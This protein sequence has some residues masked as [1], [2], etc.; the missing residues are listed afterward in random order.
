MT[1]RSLPLAASTLA[2]F[3]LAI[4]HPA[5]AVPPAAAEACDSRGNSSVD[6]GVIAW[7]DE[8]ALNTAL[9]YANRQWSTNGLTQVKLKRDDASNIADLQW[10][11]VNRTDG[12]WATRDAQWA[13]HTGA[14][15]VYFNLARL[16]DGKV[17][18]TEYHRAHVAAHELGHALGLCHTTLHEYS[19]MWPR[20]SDL[21]SENINGPMPYDRTA[22]HKLWG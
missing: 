18:G 20:H 17:N 12:D 2:V 1:T 22:Y 21:D 4:P 11:D 13:P 5:R 19:L 9:A 16:G 10:R 3:L 8:T 6:A 14:D 7:E 15:N